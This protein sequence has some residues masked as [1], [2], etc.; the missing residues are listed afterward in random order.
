M[1]SVENDTEIEHVK[2]KPGQW[3]DFFPPR[4]ERPGG[5]SISSSPDTLPEIE[6]AIRASPH[7]VVQWVFDQAKV[8]QIV[9]D[10][11]NFDLTS[12]LTTK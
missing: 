9:Q 3:V 10:C 8:D 1:L 11:L 12:F 5:F 6:L 2:F 7:P 4:Y